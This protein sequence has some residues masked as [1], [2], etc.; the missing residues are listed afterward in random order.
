M[1]KSKERFNEYVGSLLATT[2]G[3]AVCMAILA[4]AY[5]IGC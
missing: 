3:W 2:I 4:A 5:D 1:R